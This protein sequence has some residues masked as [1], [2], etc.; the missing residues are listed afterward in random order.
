MATHI[1]VLN[2]SGKLSSWLDR[3]HTTFG[4]AVET[5]SAMIPV[6]DVDVVVR[7]GGRVIPELGMGGHSPS[8]SAVYLTLDPDNPKLSIQFEQV[9]TAT[10][11]HE[12]H[13]CARHKGA[14]YGRTLG[15][16][17]ISEGLACHFESELPGG[18]VPFYA[19]AVH[20][21]ELTNLLERARPELFSS[22][23]DHRVWFF[24]SPTQ[25]IPRHAG[26]SMGFRTVQTYI[27]HNRI[28][29]SKLWALP[30]DRFWN[31]ASQHKAE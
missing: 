11:G 10:L 14:G 8:G 17:L 22:L 31:F 26:Y 20:G 30:A 4:R 7:P 18:K 9:F 12:L 16:A 19:Q 1:H 24:G 3:I 23:Y 15:E 5:I 2:A 25:G 21:D 13:H 29:A 27:V 6:E 28:P